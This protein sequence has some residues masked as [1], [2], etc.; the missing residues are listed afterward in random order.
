VKAGLKLNIHGT[1]EFLGF[2]SASGSIT[3]T[4]QTGVFSIEFDVTIALG[5]LTV[6][7]R[8]GAAIYTDSHPG[9]ALLLDVSID[10]NMFEVI[11]IKASGKLQ[12]NTSSVARTLSA[13]R[14]SHGL[15]QLQDRAERRGKVTRGAEVQ[16]I[17]RAG[18]RPTRARVLAGPT[19]APDGLLRAW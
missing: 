17:L 5:P 4:L 16:R 12:L 10:A 6:A 3:I 2:A 19:S 9:L 8:G 13:L 15:H 14:P 18:C 1:V 7:A 11:K